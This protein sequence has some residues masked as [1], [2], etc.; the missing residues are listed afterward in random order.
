MGTLA[1][2]TWKEDFTVSFALRLHREETLDL[3]NVTEEYQW[4]ELFRWGIYWDP[5]NKE[6]TPFIDVYRPTNKIGYEGFYF[7]D[8]A[9][10]IG[11]ESPSFPDGVWT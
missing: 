10:I 7:K 6:R 4:R 11:G 9:E 2:D 1:R 8:K 5:S 3:W